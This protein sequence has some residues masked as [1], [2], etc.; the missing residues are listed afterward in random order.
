MTVGMYLL[1]RLEVATTTAVASAYLLVLGLG[2]GLVMQV[3][4]LAVQNSVSYAVLGTATAGVTMLR[5]IGG[6]VGTAVFGSIFTNRLVDIRA[7]LPAPVQ[8]VLAGG[9]RLTGEQVE[10]LP[11]AARAA[12]QQGYVDAL[13]PVFLVAAGVTLAGFAVS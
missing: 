11:A 1:S 3:L 12:Y 9:G 6:S 7:N 13:T 2:L 4:V 5:G 8:D 10:A